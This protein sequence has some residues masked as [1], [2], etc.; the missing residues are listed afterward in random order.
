MVE[1]PKEGRLIDMRVCVGY[2]SIVLLSNTLTILIK[3]HLPQTER[4][5]MLIPFPLFLEV[6]PYLIP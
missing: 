2:Y 5:G 3:V 1:R 6:I 4:M